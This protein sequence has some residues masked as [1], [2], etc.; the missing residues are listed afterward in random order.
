[1]NTIQKI[2]TAHELVEAMRQAG[3]HY[4]DAD[5]MRF[6]R[7]RGPF[8]VTPCAHGVLF[9]TSEQFVGS[10]GFRAKRRWNVRLWT[11]DTVR[12]VGEFNSMTRHQAIALLWRTLGGMK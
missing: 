4:W 11:G 10:D 7:S 8:Q 5:T 6:F 3:S 12:E 9:C 2:T 1:M